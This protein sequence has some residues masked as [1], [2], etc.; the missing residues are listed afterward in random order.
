[1]TLGVL[2]HVR[3]LVHLSYT[4]SNLSLNNAITFNVVRAHKMR[5]GYKFRVT[6]DVHITNLRT[7]DPSTP[8]GL[9]LSHLHEDLPGMPVSL[10]YGDIVGA[11]DEAIKHSLTVVSEI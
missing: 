11:V 2:P 9:C 3:L 6:H 4:S 1:M 7:L 5:G 8:T 10:Q